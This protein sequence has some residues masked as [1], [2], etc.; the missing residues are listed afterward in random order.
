MRYYLLILTLLSFG[1]VGCGREEPTDPIVNVVPE[2]VENEVETPNFEPDIDE[3]DAFEQALE[4]V[5]VDEAVVF[6]ETVDDID[7]DTVQAAEPGQKLAQA[8]ASEENAQAQ[9]E[10]LIRQ[11]AREQNQT[12]EAPTGLQIRPYSDDLYVQVKGVRPAVL[13]FTTEDCE[14]C[15]AWETDLRANAGAFDQSDALVLLADFNE[16]SALVE[17]MNIPEPGYAMM[18]TGMG[19]LMGPRPS[20]RLTQSDLSF[21]FP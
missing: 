6:E 5:S 20:D 4:E 12:L 11:A 8:L 16:Q 13:Y 7:A 17:A 21:I 3:D 15:S 10:S 14:V 18:L 9:A 2:P 19:E 1:L